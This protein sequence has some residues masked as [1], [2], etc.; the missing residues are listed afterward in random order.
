M[1]RETDGCE[2]E[3]N[4]EVFEIQKDGDSSFDILADYRFALEVWKPGI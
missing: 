2:I 3:V 1:Y 4:Q